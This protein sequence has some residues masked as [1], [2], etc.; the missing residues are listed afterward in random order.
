MKKLIFILVLFFGLALNTE[1]QKIGCG[2]TPDLPDKS[3]SVAMNP[4]VGDIADFSKINYKLV[5]LPEGSKITDFE[6]N[7]KI[8]LNSSVL[9]YLL[10]NPQV[11]PQDWKDKTVVFTGT[12]FKDG[13]GSPL[14]KTL[15]Y[16][17]GTWQWGKAYPEYFLDN[18]YQ[19]QLSL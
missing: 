13:G 1:A 10:K 11:I 18:T 5:K 15:F 2:G 12:L 8:G 6:K 17:D 14:Y 4:Q 7:A 16:Q 19:C 9:D 3:W